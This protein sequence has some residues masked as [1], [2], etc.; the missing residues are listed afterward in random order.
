MVPSTPALINSE[1]LHCAVSLRS[2]QLLHPAPLLFS[3]AVL[4]HSFSG[5][6]DE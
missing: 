3:S 4:L 6:A 1:K 2:P 5:M